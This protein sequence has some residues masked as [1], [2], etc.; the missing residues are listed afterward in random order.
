MRALLTV[1]AAG[2]QVVI[3]P[4]GPRGPAHSVARGVAQLAALAAVPIVPCAAQSTRRRVLPTW[5]GMLLPLPWGRGVLVCGTPI[6][7]P[8]EGWADS[9]DAIGTALNA[10][11]RRADSLCP[12]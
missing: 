12:A 9:L 10:A 11:A 5:D 7:V 4:D 3:T 8:R 6:L 1:L 2:D